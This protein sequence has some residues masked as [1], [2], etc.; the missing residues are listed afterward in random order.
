M[1]AKLLNLVPSSICTPGYNMSLKEVTSFYADDLPNPALVPTEA[2]R[3]RAKWLAE[4]ADSRPST[5]SMALK[6]CDR[7][8]FPNIYVLLRVASTIPVTS[9]QNERANSTL[10]NLKTFL[11]SAMGQERLSSLAL[12]YIHRNM[13]IDL[14]DIVDRFKLKCST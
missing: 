12:M 2:W 10:K 3:W 13:S 7:D 14:S 6:E 8:Y 5:L 4:D 9:C 1:V 11:R